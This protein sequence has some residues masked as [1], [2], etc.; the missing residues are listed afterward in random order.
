MFRTK[1]SFS[2]NGS[3]PLVHN[4]FH[5]LSLMVIWLYAEVEGENANSGGLR[6]LVRLSKEQRKNK[7][8]VSLE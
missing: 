2:Q 8:G 1:R 6:V 5:V 7:E 3:G 4:C